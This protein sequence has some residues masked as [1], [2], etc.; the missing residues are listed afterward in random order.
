MP[1]DDVIGEQPQR[2]DITS[3]REE[4]ERAHTDMALRDARQDRAG[5]QRLANNRIS[6][7]HR[8]QRPRRRDTERVH[9]LADNVLTKHRTEPGAAV[10]LP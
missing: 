10:A 9:R 6:G 4:L 2:L 7:R 5:Q 1:V 3:G 8:G